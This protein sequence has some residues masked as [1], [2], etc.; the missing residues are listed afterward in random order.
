[1]SKPDNIKIPLPLLTQTIDLLQNW[2]L[3][4]YDPSVQYD[5]DCVYYALLKKRQSLELRDAYAKV[6]FAENEDARHSAKMNYLQQ[7]RQF[8]DDF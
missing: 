2:N 6:I 5:Y 4:D 8:N 7:K 3:A 1:M